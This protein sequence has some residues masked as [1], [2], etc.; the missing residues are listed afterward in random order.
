VIKQPLISIVITSYT[1]DRSRDVCEL[2][3]SIGAQTYPNTE[4]IFVAERSRELEK[5]VRVHAQENGMHNFKAVFNNGQPGASAARNLGIQQA[6][7]DIVAFVDDDA[8]LFPDWAVEMV[9][10]FDDASVIAVTGLSFPL[11]RAEAARW[12]PEELYWLISCTG[13]SRA[14]VKSEVRNI[15][16]QNASFR[17][18]AFRLAGVIDLALGPRDGGQGFKGREFKDG[19]I[20]EEIELSMRVRKATGKRIVL[21]PCVKIYHKVYANRLRAKYIARWSY[22]T[23]YSKHKTSR[24]YPGDGADL[25]SQERALLKRILAG[26]VPGTLA[27][28]FH[29]PVDAWRR[30]AV[31]VLALSFV[32]LGYF[33]YAFS[34][35]AA[36]PKLLVEQKGVNNTYV[37]IEE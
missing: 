11:W 31:T 16:L 34:R 22:W 26:L 33:S 20:S 35:P 17:K 2:L 21:N 5:T 19:I 4:T 14:A 10:S 27:A 18:E 36:R 15:W 28:F 12:L 1:P 13:W 23:G 9:R 7:G 8:V 29:S 25:L 24:L 30:L 6:C 32:A 3:D 37:E